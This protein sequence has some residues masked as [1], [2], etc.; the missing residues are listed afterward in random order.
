MRKLVLV[1]FSSC[2]LVASGVAVASDLRPL[3][4][5]D[6]A[7]VQELLK[8]FDPNSYDIHYRVQ[9]AKGGV[10]PVQ[11]GRALGLANIR[12]TDTVRPIQ[13]GAASSVTI[14][15]IFKTASSV[16]VIN[17]FK[18]AS[19]AAMSEATRANAA[20]GGTHASTS[21]IINIFKTADQQM[22]AQELNRILS[23]YYVP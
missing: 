14:I 17:I 5:Q 20:A 21:T 7:R 8:S 15:N 16:T 12:Q 3:S 2:L 1:V 9:D 13:G 10:K 22:K 23:K 4:P 11:T 6:A 19:P 18:E